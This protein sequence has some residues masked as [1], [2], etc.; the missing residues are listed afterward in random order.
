M[1]SSD[2]ERIGMKGPC[3][4][5]ECAHCG[6]RHEIKRVVTDETLLSYI[7]GRCNRKFEKANVAISHKMRAQ[8]WNRR[9]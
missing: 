5:P 7:C 8:G 1:K 6:K 4:I 3:E 2:M 9:R